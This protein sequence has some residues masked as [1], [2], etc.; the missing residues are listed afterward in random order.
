MRPVSQNITAL[1]ATAPVV[2][3]IYSDIFSVSLSLNFTSG[4]GAGTVT[5]QYTFDDPYATY[6]TSFAANANWIAVTSLT[7]KVADA[8]AQLTSPV[9][10]V[11]ANCTIYGSGTIKFT[12]V[13]AG[14]T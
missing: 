3:D 13:Q 2:L 10:A 8:D 12:V 14:I 11:R 6:A 5:A 4:S 1:G 9:R 7:T